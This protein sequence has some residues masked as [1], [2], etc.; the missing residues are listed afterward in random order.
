[1]GVEPGGQRLKA[2]G[3]MQE[4]GGQTWRPNDGGWRPEIGGQKA[5]A[6]SQRPEAGGQRLKARGWW[7]E[8]GGRRHETIGLKLLRGSGGV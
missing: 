1:M 5:E 4:A 8:A 7:P 6:R 2:K 3:C